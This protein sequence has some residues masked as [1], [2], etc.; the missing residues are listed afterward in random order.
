[1]LNIDHSKKGTEFKGNS[2]LNHPSV[3]K[4]KNNKGAIFPYL[5]H[6]T[7]DW[8]WKVIKTIMWKYY[9]SKRG[10]WLF[11]NPVWNDHIA[12]EDLSHIRIKPKYIMKT[13]DSKC[14]SSHEL[15]LNKIH[16]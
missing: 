6:R 7:A 11:K 9:Q 13:K 12:F 4:K 3:F 14:L 1:M 15:K 16:V 5:R 2:K 8:E 10:N